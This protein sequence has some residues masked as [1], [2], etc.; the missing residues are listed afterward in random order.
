MGKDIDVNLFPGAEFWK[1]LCSTAKTDLIFRV[2]ERLC[3]VSMVI[4]LRLESTM[5]YGGNRRNN[6]LRTGKDNILGKY[7]IESLE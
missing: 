2:I 3:S 6:F 5:L 4:I 7:T 1:M